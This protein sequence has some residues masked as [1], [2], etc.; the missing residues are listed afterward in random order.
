MERERERTWEREKEGKI[1]GRGGE[2]E[3]VRGRETERKW[4]IRKILEREKER[5]T[6]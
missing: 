1:T 3:G 5:K 2:K 4:K 6:L